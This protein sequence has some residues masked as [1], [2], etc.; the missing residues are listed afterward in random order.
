MITPELLSLYLLLILAHALGDYALQSDYIAKE[1]QQSLYV[2]FIHTMVWTCT[3]VIICFLAGYRPSTTLII[4]T[5]LIPHALMDYAKVQSAWFITVFPNPKVQ[6]AVD[7]VFH[8]TQLVI[9]ADLLLRT[10]GI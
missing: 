2:L 5:L 4:F 10:G 6:L 3:I 7:Q 1:K 9:F 8:Y